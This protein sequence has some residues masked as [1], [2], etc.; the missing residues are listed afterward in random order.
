MSG[1]GNSFTMGSGVFVSTLASLENA[2]FMELTQFVCSWH[3]PGAEQT[4]QRRS[5]A[6]RLQCRLCCENTVSPQCTHTLYPSVIFD[7][8]SVNSLSTVSM[9]TAFYSYQLIT[10]TNIS[11]KLSHK[12]IKALMS[13]FI[14]SINGRTIQLLEKVPFVALMY[15]D[16]L[17]D[18]RNLKGGP[19]Y[20][21]FL[22]H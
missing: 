10:K 12:Y 6:S 8:C 13:Q 7:M 9:Q 22:A 16:A 18:H 19:H 2:V 5:L 3:E 1:R 15:K 20:L 21:I 17:N 4:T 11:T 14:K